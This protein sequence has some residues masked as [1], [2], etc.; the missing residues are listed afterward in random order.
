MKNQLLNSYPKTKKY[1]GIYRKTLLI[2]CIIDSWKSWAIS[3]CKKITLT[4]INNILIKL[5]WNSTSQAQYK[6]EIVTL[7]SNWLM[8]LLNL[9]E[10]SGG[11]EAMHLLVEVL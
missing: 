7:K 3:H 5:N 2:T 4:E 1:V 6:A 10:L 9:T 11:F 8:A